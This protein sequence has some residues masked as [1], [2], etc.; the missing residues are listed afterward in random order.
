M[1]VAPVGDSSFEALLRLGDAQAD[2]PPAAPAAPAPL[3]A[4][5]RAALLAGR[6]GVALGDEALAALTALRAWVAE[7]GLTVSDRRWRQLVALMR[8][9]AA[10]EGRDQLDVVDLWLAPYVLSADPQTLV[11]VADWVSAEW[12]RAVA[13]P[14]P[15]LDHAV[16]AFERQLELEQ[17]LP[18]DAS[19]DD[20]A[21][22]LALARNIGRGEGPGAGDAPGSAGDAGL[23]RIRA[24]KLEDRL[25]RSFSPVHLATR[26][27][28]VDALAAR[29][30][31]A[32]T[33]VQQARDALA[34]KLERRLW[35]PPALASAWL[36]AHAQTLATLAGLQARLAATRA[37]FADLQVDPT[38]PAV[39]P[40]LP[41]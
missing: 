30:E 12:V 28:Q 10:S 31:N 17:R 27:A 35:L 1:P 8:C 40:P 19:T 23:Q 6:A 37:G 2:P 5:D 22:K 15:W 18:A 25:R 20:S 32:N 26:C 34:A 33:S 3:T 36:N 21:G 39:A 9:A 11:R 7:L 24:G 16:T 38:L 29:A 41:D 13:Q 14:L 4:A